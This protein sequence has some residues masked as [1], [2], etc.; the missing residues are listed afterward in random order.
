MYRLIIDG[1]QKEFEQE[2]KAADLVVDLI[3]VGFWKINCDEIKK[4]KGTS[5]PT[6]F[7]K[8]HVCET[9]SLTIMS[10]WFERTAMCFNNHQLSPAIKLITI[11]NQ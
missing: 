6:V 2:Q 7:V 3:N 11:N 8:P 9:D 5:V 4:G 1:F 10:D